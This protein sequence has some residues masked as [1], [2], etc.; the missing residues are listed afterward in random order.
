V[1]LFFR[2]LWLALLLLL[3]L[4]VNAGAADR[5][6]AVIMAGDPPRYREIHQAFVDASAAF[7]EGS[8][9][10]Y[11]QNPN[12]DTMSLRNSIRKAVALDAEL[13]IT[14]GTAA[15]LA[16]RDE[17][18][19]VPILFADVYD[20]AGFG[21]VSAQSLTSNRM[22]GVRGD[23][24]VQ[25]LLKYFLDATDVS[26]LSLLFDPENAEDNAQ[27]AAILE[28]AERRGLDVA[29]LS[30]LAAKDFAEVLQKIPLDAGGLFVTD[31]E[32]S[33]N[34]LPRLLA[35]AEQ[36]KLPLITQLAGAA[37]QGAFMV[38]ETSAR[39]QG[40]KLAELAG[41]VL[42]GASVAELPMVRPR[43]VAFIVN[44]KVAKA[45][46]LQ[47]PIKTLSVASRLIR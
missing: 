39:E 32:N 19:P 29:S 27:R 14:Y 36:R 40:E 2:H 23:A 35:Y 4:S 5:L 7:C 15:T 46:G 30:V 47:V 43:E 38:I 11:L 9:R 24:P 45:Y 17:A 34:Y 12:S 22:S 6:V 18:P 28:S 10:V 41:Q 1:K 16:A 37:E 20:P 31:C 42:A 25:A 21:L 3:T 8:C 33:G 44:L 26:K 13:I